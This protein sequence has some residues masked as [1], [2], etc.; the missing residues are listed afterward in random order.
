MVGEVARCCEFLIS[1]ENVEPE[2]RVARIRMPEGRGNIV[3]G[4]CGTR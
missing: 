3:S 2:V 4:S 1:V